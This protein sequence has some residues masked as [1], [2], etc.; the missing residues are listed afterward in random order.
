MDDTSKQKPT[1]KKQRDNTD[2]ARKPLYQQPSDTEIQEIKRKYIGFQKLY[3]EKMTF[4]R[5][6]FKMTKAHDGYFYEKHPKIWIPSG[7]YEVKKRYKHGE[8]GL[9]HYYEKNNVD[10]LADVGD[11][12]DKH[13]SK[14]E[15]K[16]LEEI[17][18]GNFLLVIEFCSKCDEHAS[19][20]QHSSETFKNLAVSY[21]KIIQEHFPFIKIVLK[22]IDVDIIR[23]SFDDKNKTKQQS[24]TGDKGKDAVA[25]GETFYDQNIIK[26]QLINQKFKDCKIGAFELTLFK[27]PCN[28]MYGTVNNQQQQQ[29]QQQRSRACE[30]CLWEIHSKLKSKK[31]PC[32]D[33]VLTKIRSHLPKFDLNLL[34]FDKEDYTEKNKMNNIKVAIHSLK[35]DSMRKYFDK[36]EEEI[37]NAS[38]PHKRLEH[39]R[40]IKRL[41]KEGMMLTTNDFDLHSRTR[42]PSAY[43]N[44]NTTTTGNGRLQTFSANRTGGFGDTSGNRRITTSRGFRAT[45]NANESIECDLK[46]LKGQMMIEGTTYVDINDAD[47]END[48]QQQQQQQQVKKQ[49]SI[50][51]K[52]DN[53]NNEMV[54]K[55]QDNAENVNVFIVFKN[56]PFDTY[57]IETKETP[58]FLPS[59]T[60]F[61]PFSVT[62]QL[63]TPVQFP[64]KL[65]PKQQIVYPKGMNPNIQNVQM[66]KQLGL[67]HQ[68]EATLQII[69]YSKLS[70]TNNPQN[71]TEKALNVETITS[72]T[73]VIT[74]IN[75]SMRQVLTVAEDKSSRGSNGGNESKTA[76]TDEQ[77][78]Q[79]NTGKLRSK[80]Y[81]EIKTE[82]GTYKIEIED[83]K[84]EP[85]TDKIT[86]VQGL[87]KFIKKLPE[88]KKCVINITVLAIDLENEDEDEDEQHEEDKANDNEEHEEKKK[89]YKF[90][91]IQNAEVAIFK[92]SSELYCEGIT[93]KDGKMQ[94]TAEKEDNSL[95]FLV[96]KHGYYSSQR[97][98]TRNHEMKLNDDNNYEF[99][100]TFVLVKES[101]II[102]REKILFIS[103]MNVN[104]K[105]FEYDFQFYEHCKA[106]KRMTVIDAQKNNGV[107]I[108]V[109]GWKQEDENE[110]RNEDDDNEE[111]GENQYE[112]IVRV[113]LKYD[114]EQDKQE[115]EEN[116]VV[117]EQDEQ[118]QQQ[119]NEQR[120]VA[121]EEVN[122]NEHEIIGEHDMNGNEQQ[123]VNDIK[124]TH[125]NNSNNKHSN[126][127][128]DIYD[129]NNYNI[130]IVDDKV[131]VERK[132]KPKSAN[133]S[134]KQE[135]KDEKEIIDPKEKIQYLTKIIC[136][137]MIYTPT[138]SFYI[139][140]PNV[141]SKTPQNVDNTVTEI[142]QQ[143]Q[144]Q[145]QSQNDNNV[146]KSEK[147]KTTK[148]GLYWDLGWIDLKNKI[149]YETSTFFPLSNPPKRKLFFEEWIEFL[150]KLIDKKV[151]KSLFEYFQF[152]ES[153][154]IVNKNEK[155]RV[156]SKI[157]FCDILEALMMPEADEIQSED[158]FEEDF[159]TQ[160]IQYIVDI[161]S[162]GA[163]KINEEGVVEEDDESISYNLVKKKIASNLK[164]FINEDF[165]NEFY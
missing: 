143:Q 101:D 82:P 146:S 148:N 33:T 118:Q 61:K 46:C 144:Q 26:G 151:Y 35:K 36:I 106:K 58:D 48:E 116:E 41:Q 80:G 108:A 70:F 69:L 51:S 53:S 128:E 163:E 125:S 87:N 14:E 89:E 83:D 16:E 127:N 117:A 135:D 38:N 121:M 24:S 119:H 142:D 19:I 68:T 99:N 67:N 18:A 45:T 137:G 47:N 149:F 159:K 34:I 52:K 98:F 1:Q 90:I 154:L 129:E 17:E 20:T 37:G 123:Q 7:V 102:Q 25:D 75:T 160:I 100:M 5:R 141:I 113:G 86:L 97:F 73:I 12:S 107:I 63:K 49:Q 32:V 111:D 72:A 66:Y 74:N 55:T 112:D 22:P 42:L 138:S 50:K 3:K 79:Y 64:P 158:N 39:L 28:N 88:E 122:D 13:R 114:F 54:I 2:I 71:E 131:I 132:T 43:T 84:Y 94:F 153:R 29:Q 59:I 104:K 124:S 103:Y 60:I 150:Q 95:S 93:N 147:E 120:V 156:L 23:E 140:I 109:F 126:E 110:S 96:N 91:P 85:F 31:W 9:R 81:Y 40:T 62:P 139:N 65:H 161:M 27:K 76:N 56:L 21:Q 77:L 57:I 105:L 4:I 133:K 8:T 164:N 92:N 30:E 145:Q 10:E 155:D 152:T 165:G 44:N 162:T 157:K 115:K 6:N 136:E 78:T 134:K 15:P 11:D 130:G